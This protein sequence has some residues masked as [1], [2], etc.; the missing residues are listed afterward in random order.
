[1]RRIFSFIRTV[2][3]LVIL[4]LMLTPI[5]GPSIY[6]ELRGVDAPAEI[7]AKREA[8]DVASGIWT[9][10]LYVDVRYQPPD[11][12]DPEIANV[13]VDAATYDQLH[14]EDPVR[15]RYPANP[16]L[17]RITLLAGTRLAT[18]RPFSALLARMGSLLGRIALGLL[19]W[20]VLLLLWTKWRRW[21]LGLAL[22]ALMIGGVI[23]VGSGW[24]S[25][26]PDGELVAGSA[27]V[28][29]DHLVERVWGSR[30]RRAEEAVQPYQIVELT[31][32][33]Q[34]SSDSVVGVDMID[35]GSVA[36]IE[37]GAPV[38]MH[39]SAADPRWV[40]IDGASRTY[41]WKNLRSF[42]LIAA[43]ILLLV[44]VAWIV[45][46]RRRARQPRNQMPW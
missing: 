8:I 3:S 17:R 23:Y 5:V 14:A 1:M 16:T 18:Q 29:A 26:A 32:V 35:A 10:R 12:P 31:F 9:R 4:A 25:P 46:R 37:A 33:P 11:A 27:T 42:G 24:P 20:L 22:V 19:I 45:A 30:R 44:I 2:I 6:V 39:Y 15:I 21:W 43:G 36:G 34:G 13:A 38:A 40:S 28:R 7:V 41:Y